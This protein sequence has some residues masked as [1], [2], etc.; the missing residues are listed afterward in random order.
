MNKREQEEG[1]NQKK[2]EN[3]YLRVRVFTQLQNM[4]H[5]HRRIS[6]TSFKNILI[7]KVGLL[8]L[9]VRNI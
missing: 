2:D 4:T 5:V 8:K 1:E 3:G 6:I 7:N 9:P